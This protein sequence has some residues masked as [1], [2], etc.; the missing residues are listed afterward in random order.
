MDK[1]A[2]V[3]RKETLWIAARAGSDVAF[4]QHEVESGSDRFLS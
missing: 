2:I 1:F 4:M 3:S